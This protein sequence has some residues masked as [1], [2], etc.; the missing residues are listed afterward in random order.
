MLKRHLKRRLK[1]LARF[2]SF[3]DVSKI[4]INSRCLKF[5][6]GEILDLEFKEL[7]ASFPAESRIQIYHRVYV[8]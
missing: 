6:S 3:Y 8:I 7:D 2:T 5:A 1:D 4:R